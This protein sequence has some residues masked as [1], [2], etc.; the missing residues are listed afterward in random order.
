MSFEDTTE[1]KLTRMCEDGEMTWQRLALACMAY[2]PEDD[3]AD[4]ARCEELLPLEDDEA[5]YEVRDEDDE[6]FAEYDTLEEANENAQSQAD[7]CDC[8]FTVYKMTDNGGCED[9]M[10]TF[11]AS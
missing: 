8:S 4:M 6:C 1:G 9:E 5:V 3:I 11:Y 7:E 2:M 10:E